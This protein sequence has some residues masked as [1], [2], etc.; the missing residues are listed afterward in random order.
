MRP[1]IHAAIDKFRRGD[2]EAAGQHDE[3]IW[4]EALDGLVTFASPESL[5]ILQQARQRRH[6]DEAAGKRFRLWL[7]E[8][9]HHVE[10]E[11]RR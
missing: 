6:D 3:E 11:L 9:I 10:F 8:A 2:E 1:E 7:E 5:V 4:Q